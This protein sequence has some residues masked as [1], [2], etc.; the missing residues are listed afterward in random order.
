MQELKFK[1]EAVQ[2]L[3]ITMHIYIIPELPHSYLFFTNELNI[4]DEIC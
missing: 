4:S 2:A 3:A 1:L